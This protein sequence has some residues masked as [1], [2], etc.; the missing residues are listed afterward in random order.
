MA[1]DHPY[2]GARVALLTCHGKEQVL[3][4]P[5]EA[6]LGASL[7]VTSGFDTDTLGTFTREVPRPGT[8]REAALRKARL[9]CELSGHPLGLGSEGSFGPGPLGFGV[10]DLELL[11]LFDARQDL[12]ITGYALEPGFA[13]HETVRSLP[14][15]HAFAKEARF[16]DHGLVLRPDHEAHP[17]VWKGLRTPQTLAEAF[18]AARAVASTGRV[19]VEHDLRAH[20]HPTR[21]AVIGKAMADLMTRVLALCP[22]CVRPGFGAES[23]VPGLPCMACGD[24]TE[25]PRAD[26]WACVACDHREERPRAGAPF[27]DPGRCGA[28]NP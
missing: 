3:A 11:V 4:P 6:A 7:D 26:A 22:A 12:A 21:M 18:E 15:L 16:P 9:A 19:F 20:Q 17:R 14:E 24:P 27:A 2:R 10:W 25:V 8:Q 1:S 23:P 28:C 13:H 5:F